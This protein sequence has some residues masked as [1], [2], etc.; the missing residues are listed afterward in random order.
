[1]EEA[2]TRNIS[3]HDRQLEDT[4]LCAPCRPKGKNSN[5]RVRKGRELEDTP[6]RMIKRGL[7]ERYGEAEGEEARGIH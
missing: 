3:S 1:M 5:Q 7:G 6:G 4:M 2:E